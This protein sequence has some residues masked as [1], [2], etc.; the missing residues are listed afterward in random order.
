MLVGP[1]GGTRTASD[2]NVV[3]GAN[4]SALV[5]TSGSPKT[6]KISG[7]AVVNGAGNYSFVLTGT[8]LGTASSTPSAPDTIALQLT[9]PSGAPGV[10]SLTFAARG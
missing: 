8:D 5:I 2:V 4:L 3:Q 9:A 1:R 6:A 10:A 7:K